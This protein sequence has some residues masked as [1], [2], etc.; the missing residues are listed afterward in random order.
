MKEVY[1]DASSKSLMDTLQTTS[2]PNESTHP[3]IIHAQ[4]AGHSNEH[5]L[6]KTIIWTRREA[7]QEHVREEKEARQQ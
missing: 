1:R 4:I 5:V 2:D 3:T 7:N 6:G